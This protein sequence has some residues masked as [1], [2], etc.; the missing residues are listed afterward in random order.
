L[1]S[2]SKQQLLALLIAARASRERDFLMI[3]VGF[4]HGLRPSEVVGLKADDIRDG[5]LDVQRLK[6]SMRTVQPLVEDENPLLNERTALFD[7]TVGM[8]GNQRLFPISR[9]QFGRLF[10]RYGK[11]AGIP[12]HLCH[13]HI[14]KHSIAMQ[15]IQLAGIENVRQYLGHKSISS[16][17]AYLKVSDADAAG[18]IKNALKV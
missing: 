5:H 16:T 9:R 18:A 15:T 3:L 14:L 7:Y 6:G 13:P 17:G 8:L 1:Q 10:E 12:R 4:A 11:A 2:L